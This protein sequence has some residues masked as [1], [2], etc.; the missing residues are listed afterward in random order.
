MKTNRIMMFLVEAM[1]LTGLFI[2]CGNGAEI[3]DV[4]AVTYTVTYMSDYGTV[5]EAIT[6]KENTVLTE[7]QL[8]VLT[9]E[10]R[11]FAGWFDEDVRALKEIYTV[12]KNVTLTAKWNTETY[13]V[14]FHANGGS[15]VE[16]QTVE[17]GRLIAEPAA[18]VKEAD[19]AIT[20]FAG[21]FT[22]STLETPFDFNTAIT[23]GMELY[24]KWASYKA[25]DLTK[26]PEGTDGTAG[27]AGVYV[28][29][30]DWP[31]TVKSETVT[32]DEKICV[33]VGA[34][35]YYYG[36]DDEWYAKCKEN[37]ASVQY[38]YSD[39]TSVKKSVENS[40][41]YFKV[42]PIKW[43]VL[44]STKKLLLAENILARSSFFSSYSQERTI[45]DE[46]VYPN[47]YEHSKIRAYLNG[48]RYYVSSQSENSD[49]E[50]KG[51]L[52]SAFT[53]ELQ[54]KIAV[55]EVDNSLPAA[56]PAEYDSLTE[57]KK[58]KDWNYVPK[59]FC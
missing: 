22:D 23:S 15:S 12:T 43:R 17:Y 54:D 27:T 20:V 6:V 40:T 14:T 37:S 34:N 44:D 5:P 11:I 9:A 46:T 16:S 7:K 32:V 48:L 33:T 21:W 56:L 3:P 13:N 51:F 4:N 2:S 19:D 26:L 58:S 35:I 53:L 29:F 39:G 42:E 38:T 1:C 41:K 18:P 24:A 47:N 49:Y 10:G 59:F 57:E 31:N 8:P 52:Q 45:E 28:L 55:T 25:T 30:G 36:N 50:S